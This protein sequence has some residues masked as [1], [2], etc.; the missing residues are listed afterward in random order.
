[1]RTIINNMGIR[2]KI[3]L[4]ISVFAVITVL[5]LYKYFDSTILDAKI[6][7]HVAEA[8]A[9]IVSSE[10][11]R[12]YA[13]D[14]FRLGVFKEGLKD[15]DQ[16]LHT[17]P[18][19]AAMQVIQKKADEMGVIFKVPKIS[20]RNPKNL[21]DE[22]EITVLKKLEN[23]RLNEYWEF[24]REKAQLR[25]FRP[26]KLTKECLAC[27]GD[28]ATSAELWGNTEGNDV[29]GTRMENWKEGEVHGAFEIITNMQHAVMEAHSDSRIGALIVIA[30]G[31]CIVIVGIF[32][33]RWLSGPI[34]EFSVQA[35][36]VAKGD[37]RFKHTPLLEK[38]MNTG[39]EMG[40][41][42]RSFGVMINSLRGIIRQVGESSASVASA[43]I[44]ISASTEQ[45]AAGAQQQ[46][47]QA[48]EV[49]SAV[50]QMTKTII[51]NA[52]T[53]QETAETS[54]K[55]KMAAEQGGKAVE[56]TVNGMKRIAEVVRSSA[57]TVQDLGKSSD[58]I[59]EIIEVIDEIADQTN[60]L[61]LNA[62][63]EAA[64]AGEQGRGF[65]VVADEVRKLAERTT[66]ATK[67]IA[68]MI[69]QIQSETK[70]AVNAMEAGTKEV[71]RGI[72]LADKAGASLQEIVSI[73][74]QVTQMISQIAAANEQ[75]SRASELIAKNVEG[76]SVVTQETANSAHQV[77]LTADDLSK[78]TGHLEEIV[79]K[80]HLS[81]SEDM[82]SKQHH[83]RN[84]S[85]PDQNR[86]SKAVTS[87]GRIVERSR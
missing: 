55:A 58:Q 44:E 71:D 6:Q 86:G 42:A 20:P 32:I 84:Q 56:D 87:T 81:D 17:V 15:K 38:Q 85:A 12:E 2:S 16:I 37:L 23:G 40:L 78:L 35:D 25:Y 5:I 63:I 72:L 34:T 13:A 28:P 14:Q 67:E 27:H 24:D 19:V 30:C 61:A 52:K 9:L 74:Q 54:K 64:R 18:V 21:P 36:S 59:G 43:S 29:T 77:A 62:A 75:Q 7:E 65:A 70:G 83:S 45:M 1:M 60:L 73:S 3:I 53:A 46:T 47:Q 11:A 69:K 8:R 76:M 31:I 66:K 10:S 33:A 39:D 79:G 80:F 57:V 49:A 51:E 48:A 68:V 4:P 50:E 26:V 22:Y 82:L 41:L